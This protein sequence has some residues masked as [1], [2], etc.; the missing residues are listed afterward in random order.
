MN[1]FWTFYATQFFFAAIFDLRQS[2][3]YKL[4][5][6]V[7]PGGISLKKMDYVERSWSWH[8]GNNVIILYPTNIE[9]FTAK[10]GRSTY[11]PYGVFSLDSAVWWLREAAKKFPS[12]FPLLMTITIKR[13]AGVMAL[14]AWLLVEEFF[15]AASLILYLKVGFVWFLATTLYMQNVWR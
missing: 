3:S 14:L 15:F 8:G 6:E 11:T 10:R 1:L 4:I 12:F 7:N 9:W 5:Y 2:F 13:G